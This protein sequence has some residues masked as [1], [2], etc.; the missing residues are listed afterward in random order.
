METNIKEINSYTR[1]LDIT[2]AWDQIQGEFEKEFLRVKSTYSMKGF[3]KGKVPESIVKKNIG[4]S[5]EAHFA[6][7]SINTYYRKALEELK[8]IPINQ[9]SIDKLEFKEGSPLSF[10]ARFEVHPVVSLPNYSKKFK[11]KA[12]RYIAD[13]DD[14]EQALTN[15]QEQ[16]AKVKTIDDGAKSGHFIR[17]DFHMLDE[18][19]NPITQSK[20]EN[21]YIRLGFGL[22]KDESEKE[23]LGAKAGDELKVTVKNKDKNIKYGIKVNKVEEQILPDIDDHLAKT[24]NETV[25][26]L[27]ELKKIIKDDIQKSLDNDHKEAI[28]KEIIDYFVKN[29]KIE[30][31]ESMVSLYLDQI[32][33]D[34][35]KRNQPFEEDKFKENYQSHA[36]WN[37]KWYLIKDE[38]IGKE[39]IDVSDDEINSKI[40]DIISDNKENASQ[41]KTFYK[42][43]KNRNQLYSELRNDK[44][45]DKL[46]EFIKLKVVEESTKDLRKKQAAQ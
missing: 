26:S 37:I 24:I 39:L 2:I 9:A 20:M 5:V 8:L 23:L 16:N 31:P 17:G 7:D 34:L 38:I 40:N 42:E 44:L 30:A 13:K 46:S 29:T 43:S 45:F 21:Q 4:P 25:K 3:R 6:E 22:F 41:I 14:V 11:I 1:Q 19:G 35:E 36:E 15:Y 32:K 12:T 27:A 10:S 28:R 18:S 33:D